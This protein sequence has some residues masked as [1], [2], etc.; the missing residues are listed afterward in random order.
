MPRPSRPGAWLLVALAAAGA[1]AGCT[2]KPEPCV[3]T[4]VT[5]VEGTG[6]STLEALGL[7]REDLRGKALQAF[8]RT[9]GFEVPAAGPSPGARR[10][11]G[12]VSLVDARIATRGATVAEVLLRLEVTPGED[13][14][15]L[16]ETV[17]ASETVE[18]GEPV[19]AAFRRAIEGG[20]MRAASGLALALAEAR[21]PDAA[22]I[23]DL[24][25][26][27]PRLRDLAVGVLADR[28]NVAA[29]P[30]LLTRLQDPDPEIADRAVGALAQIGDPRA[31][32]PIIE[33]SR[34]REG[35]FVAQMVRVVGDIGGAEAEAYLETMAAGH[36]DPA[37]VSA[38]REALRDARRRR[39][40]G[41][42][43]G[44]AR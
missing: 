8:G 38:A 23:R 16:S 33:L 37:V 11:R 39:A 18:P 7:P 12:G 5:V 40:D 20:A 34:R 29:V 21:K 31:V 9:A 17:R 1:K 15:T 27:D 3:I 26:A 10:C 32:G 28:K 25:S 30:A 4:G 19:L 36:P 42:G 43:R 6:P 24:E 22:V 14:D 41:S 2:R 44:A 13:A 35:P